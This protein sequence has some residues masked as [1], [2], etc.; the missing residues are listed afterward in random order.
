MPSWLTLDTNTR[1]V[2]CS[3]ESG[4]ADASTHGSLTALHVKPDGTLRE[5]AVAKTVGGGVNSVIY[6]SDAGKKFIAIAH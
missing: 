4:T 5:D 1:T 3:D 2:Y 6:E